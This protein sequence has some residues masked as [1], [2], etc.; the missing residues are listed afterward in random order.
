MHIDDIK[1]F[2]DKKIRIVTTTKFTYVGRIESYGDTFIRFRDKYD[3]LIMLSLDF[4]EFI[5]EIN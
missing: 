3:K 1:Q 5:E 4:I 2:Y